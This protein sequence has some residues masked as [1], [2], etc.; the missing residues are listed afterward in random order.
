MASTRPQVSRAPGTG[1]QFLDILPP[2][3]RNE[4]Y[5][6]LLSNPL[7][8]DAIGS[9]QITHGT[10]TAVWTP[11]YLSPA[12]LRTCRQIYEEASVILYEFNTFYF[13]CNEPWI[14]DFDPETRILLPIAL[15][16]LTRR[17]QGKL[18]SGEMSLDNVPGMGKA[19]RWRVFLNTW[20][21]SDGP[22][23]CVLSAE[24]IA[25]L[26][27]ILEKFTES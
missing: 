14:D 3:I 6:Y 13:I 7:L 20:I 10:P 25:I 2:E 8:A 26:D 24:W 18:N 1:S 19:R 9:N 5:K 12:L 27:E 16:P 11:Y 22:G 15:C 17:C 4:I 21:S 23:K